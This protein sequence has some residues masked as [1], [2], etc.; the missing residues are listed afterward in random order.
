[1][2][3]EGLNIKIIYLAALHVDCSL[4]Y[5]GP[6]PTREG[7]SYF[8]SHTLQHRLCH[9]LFLSLEL[10]PVR[11]SSSALQSSFPFNA[12][13]AAP[14]RQTSLLLPFSHSLTLWKPLSLDIYVRFCRGLVLRLFLF[15]GFRTSQGRHYHTYLC[16][17][18]PFRSL[19][20]SHYFL[21]GGLP[22]R[23]PTSFRYSSIR[24]SRRG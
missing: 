12:F 9:S 5:K 3:C 15:S 14:K 23:A 19:S 1:M 16:S 10:V 24:Y 17:S 4:Q 7:R 22:L 6:M 13:H 21:H 2:S 8:I 11:Q 18:Q 20:A